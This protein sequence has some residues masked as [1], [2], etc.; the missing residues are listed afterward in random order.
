MGTLAY[1]AMGAAVLDASTYEGVEA[2]RPATRQAFAVVLLSSLAAGVGA[3]GLDGPAEE[4]E[5]LGERRLPR[6]GMADDGEGPPLAYFFR[7]AHCRVLLYPLSCG[8]RVH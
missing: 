6:V 3:G 5:L 2:E 8:P 1:R 4:Q 7:V